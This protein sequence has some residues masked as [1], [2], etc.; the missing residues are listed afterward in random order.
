MGKIPKAFQLSETDIKHQIRDY[1]NAT[2]AFTFHLLAGV[3]AYKG[4]PDRIF[5]YKGVVVF[6]EI[7]KP[8]GV[9]SEHQKE[10]ERACVQ[11]GG[12]YVLAK[13]VDDVV[14][15][16]NKINRGEIIGV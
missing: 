2:G 1:L 9:Q 5:V 13:S 8:S 14:Q 7:K 11:A 4:A 10:F 15:V 16:V 6:L 12:F 3:G